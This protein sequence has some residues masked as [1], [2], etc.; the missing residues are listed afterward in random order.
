MNQSADDLPRDDL[1]R[2]EL[3]R[4]VI[5]A[6]KS[7]RKIEAIKALRVAWGL[8]LRDAKNA[9][10]AYE[11]GGAPAMHGRLT[12]DD[13]DS[14]LPLEV[15]DAIRSNR[16]IEAIKVLRERRGLG[17][18]EA[19]EQVDAYC[20]ENPGQEAHIQ[21]VSE[22]GLGGLVWIV[23]IAVVAYV[24]YRFLAPAQ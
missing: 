9:I 12:T 19:K 21:K 10:E 7:G 23:A 20:R 2:D 16:K 24:A 3:P 1:S 11:H 6:I 5:A 17:L 22:S 18:R 14:G 4:E 15:I 8:G 13:S